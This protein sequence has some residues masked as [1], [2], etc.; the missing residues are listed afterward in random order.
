MFELGGGHARDLPELTR[1]MCE[2]AVMHF[3][4]NFRQGHLF[5]DQQFFYAFDL[6]TDIEFLDC[7]MLRFRKEIGHI[8]IIIPELLC[9]V[10]GEVDYER[11]FAVIDDFGDK[12]F[13]PLDKD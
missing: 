6:M 12:I 7:G 5:V 2:T 4:G 11:F 9:Q 8:G 10:D 1:E 3:V 13:Y